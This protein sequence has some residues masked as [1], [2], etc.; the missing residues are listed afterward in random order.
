MSA[1]IERRYTYTSVELRAA[2]EQPKI[3]GYAAVFN[4]LSQNLG[5][6]VERVAP[7]FFNKSRGDNWPDVLAR[8]DHDNGFLLGTTAAH[9]LELRVDDTGLDYVVMPPK[10]RADI[11]ELVS[12]GDIQKSSF[13]FQVPAGGDDW[14]TTDQGYPMRT[15]VTGRLLDVAPVVSPSYL[16][17]TSGLRSLAEKFEAEYEEVRSLAAQNELRR[18][19]V[20]TEAGMATARRTDAPAAYAQLLAKKQD[21]WG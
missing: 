3:G 10:A 17:T 19:F 7:S 6:F 1:A 13:A 4:K 21:P 12:R 11:V 14:A 8:F 16:D 20:K 5:G 9:T 18:F 2:G 15:L